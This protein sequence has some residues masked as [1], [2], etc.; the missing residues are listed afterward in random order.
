MQ[1]AVADLL[2]GALAE[3]KVARAGDV[4][5]PEAQASALY[6]LNEWLD[7]LNGNG[8][9]LYASSFPQF[10]LIP[11]HQPHTIGG[12]GSGADWINPTNG[13]SAL[14]A[15]PV[16]IKG[17]NLILPGSI[18]KK[19]D[20]IGDE[21]WMAVT[22]FAI[23]T[24]IPK[25]LAY[26]P[27]WP[28]GSIR[29][30]PVPT[31]AYSLELWID[32]LLAQLLATDIIDLP[33]G[34]PAAMRLTLAELLAP[35][36]N[37]VVSRKTEQAAIRARAIAFGTNDIMPSIRTRDGGMPGGTHRGNFDYRDGTVGGRI[38]GGN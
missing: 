7:M 21:D 24:T 29:L 36:F 28:T 23:T 15:R 31:A 32:T 26:S 33:M 17:A 2:F 25:K 8:R 18:R 35:T 13:G 12:T 9:A 38:G 22:A 11:N 16:R 14:I 6:I 5:E 37:A 1:V 19:V 3:I 4:L 20:V 27:D 10:T 30:W 34:Y